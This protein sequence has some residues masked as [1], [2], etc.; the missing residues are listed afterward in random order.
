MFQIELFMPAQS[1]ILAT[2]KVSHD[3][4]QF[5]YQQQGIE[6]VRWLIGKN[7]PSFYYNLMPTKDG[8]KNYAQAMVTASDFATANRL[9]PNI[10]KALDDQ[11]PH[12][13]ILVRKLEQGPLLMPPLNYVFMAQT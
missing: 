12:A 13:Q 9:I 5:L 4:S 6:K 10:Q 11:M 8:S 7:T 3:I 1:S 2:E